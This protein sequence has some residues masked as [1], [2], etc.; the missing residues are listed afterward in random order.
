MFYSIE[1]LITSNNNYRGDSPELI[2]IEHN[3]TVENDWQNWVLNFIDSLK[4]LRGDD[5]LNCYSILNN[6]DEWAS[7]IIDKKIKCNRIVFSDNEW[8]YLPPNVEW[9]SPSGRFACIELGISLNIG[10]Y[11][12]LW[13][14]VNEELLKLEFHD[15]EG[16]N[17]TNGIMYCRTHS[18]IHEYG[19][20]LPFQ[21]NTNS[22]NSESE[23]VS[24]VNTASNDV[25]FEERKIAQE[26]VIK[27]FGTKDDGEFDLSNT[28][29]GKLIFS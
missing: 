16:M 27:I 7:S 24:L 1:R 19:Y 6:F 5:D 4:R 22:I 9:I 28:G 8:F 14:T 29:I 12:L 2:G 26:L 20:N 23:W 21:I 10:N 17:E 11:Y 18:S 25:S 3:T 13:D 15:L